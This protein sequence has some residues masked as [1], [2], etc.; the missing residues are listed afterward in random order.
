MVK[1]TLIILGIILFVVIVIV[2][3]TYFA[4]R[5]VGN[6]AVLHFK[7]IQ[8]GEKEIV[9]VHPMLSNSAGFYSGKNV[10][11][12]NNG[13]LIVTIYISPLMKFPGDH[14]IWQDITIPNTYPDITEI[15]LGGGRN[16]EDKIIWRKGN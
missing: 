5:Y 11:Y 9:L 1:N 3:V 16:G 14:P 12:I 15:R 2:L 13:I 7:E 10:S 8:V 6:S 4:M